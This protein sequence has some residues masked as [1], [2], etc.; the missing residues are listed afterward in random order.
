[1][2]LGLFAGDRRLPEALASLDGRA[3]G[4]VKAVLDAE[5]FAGKAGQSPTSTRAIASPAR[6][7]SSWG[8]G[9]GGSDAGDD[10]ARRGQRHPPRP[11]PRR[12]HRR[13][14]GVRRPPAAAAP[15][16]CGHRGTILGTYAFDRY[17][18]ETSDKF[19]DEALVVPPDARSAR[20][21]VEGVRA[22]EIFARATWFARDLVNAPANEVHPTHLAEVAERLA[23][24]AR[25]SAK[26]LDRGEC[27]ELGMGA[28]LGVAAGSEQPPKFIHL[29]YRPSGRPTKRVAIIGKGITFDA[30]ASTSRAQRACC[31]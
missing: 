16:P 14:R 19:V 21:V 23:Q 8:W 12:P 28:F 2:I 22:G 25:L 26:I 15:G 31:G 17:K 18:R 7:W 30:G 1:M 24:P 9:R 10:P 27:A 29:T 4:L 5:R 3:G 20:D 13:H 6:G 11:G